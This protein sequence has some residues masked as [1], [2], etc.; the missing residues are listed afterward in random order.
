M[1]Q[2]QVGLI[3]LT[4]NA[5]VRVH[6]QC[7]RATFWELDP[8]SDDSFNV[9]PDIDKEAW[10]TAQT[11]EYGSCGFNIVNL[12]SDT[13]KAYATALFC[14]RDEA[15]GSLRMPTAPASQ[16]AWLLTSLHID[17]EFAGR[18]WEAVLLDACIMA[19]TDRG[20][21]AVEAFGLH[22]DTSTSADISPTISPT[23]HLADEL[24]A[25]L[26]EQAEEIGLMGR[27]VLEGAGFR[28]VEDDP[29]IPRL[30]LDLPPQHNVL[31]AHEIEQLLQAVSVPQ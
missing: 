4:Y 1:P 15:P 11:F 20:I 8:L 7:A 16:D 19:L 28:I 2:R 25:S 17:S 14:P 24:T 21:R 10:L 27:S 6:P 3:P 18:G 5:I 22:D 26:V 30:R 13:S 23:S 12:A 31:S 29:V 9:S